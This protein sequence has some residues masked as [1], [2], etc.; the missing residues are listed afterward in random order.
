[1]NRS[2]FLANNWLESRMS[3][4]SLKHHARPDKVRG[5][6]FS[7]VINWKSALD[8]IAHMFRDKILCEQSESTAFLLKRDTPM[9][10]VLPS[11]GQC[12][13]HKVRQEQMIKSAPLPKSALFRHIFCQTPRSNRYLA[14]SSNTRNL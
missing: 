6:D 2:I 13:Q 5:L 12:R 4:T 14:I 10:G 11:Q 3:C 9:N 8:N 7:L 1:M